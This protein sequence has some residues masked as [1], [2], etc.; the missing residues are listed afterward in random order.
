VR[1]PHFL[2]V[3]VTALLAASRVCG[4]D[5]QLTDQEKAEGWLVLFDGQ[6]L[7]G[8]Q[9]S[10]QRP[11]K[12]PVEQSAINPHGCG[13]YMMIHEKPRGNFVLALDFKISKGCNSGVFV[14]T[15]PLTPRPGKDVGYNGIEV[16]I[17]D[18]TTAGYHDTGAI[19]DLVK[20]MRNAMK[21]VGE[22]NHMVVTCDRNILAVELN[23]EQV[24]RMDLDEW[25]EPN[26]RPDGSSHKFDVAYKDHPRQGYIGLQD[27]GAACWFKNIKLKPLP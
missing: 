16:Q 7:N 25:K 3:A 20:P 9:T 23:G 12:T 21:P 15:N 17:L 19:Y 2:A 1:A 5:N 22:W 18:S 13:G 26:K 8:W 10:S 14:R 27:H 11:S 4:G 6:T 24:S